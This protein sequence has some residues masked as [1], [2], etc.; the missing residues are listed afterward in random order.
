MLMAKFYCKASRISHLP[1]L[2]TLQGSSSRS[3]CFLGSQ[4]KRYHRRNFG[5]AEPFPLRTNLD[6]TSFE[7]EL[8]P[9]G[10]LNLELDSNFI[11]AF[12]FHNCLMLFFSVRK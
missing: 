7:A 8:G 6:K 4:K 12:F 5:G 11:I 1:R 10:E 3:D 2:G 9:P